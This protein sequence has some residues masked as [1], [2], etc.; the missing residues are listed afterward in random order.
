MEPERQERPTWTF[1]T[2]QAHVLICIAAD[3][4]VRLRDVATLVG[5]TERSAQII[6]ADLVHAGYVTRTRIGRR[7]RYEV[8]RD[9][10]L[11]HR[12]ERDHL[13]GELLGTLESTD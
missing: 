13:I 5:I 6:L 2:N 11:R 3:P 7:N 12:L 9:L 1:L 10:P 8:H 4:D